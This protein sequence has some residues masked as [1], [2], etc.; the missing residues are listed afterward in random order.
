MKIFLIVHHNTAAKFFSNVFVDMG[1]YVYIPPKKILFEQVTISGNRVIEYTNIEKSNI[2]S[3]IFKFLNDVDFYDKNAVISQKI[4]RL[5]EKNFDIIISTHAVNN[6]Y[7]VNSKK[8]IYY[9]VWGASE[10]N[11]IS[12]IIKYCYNTFY[13]KI[14]KNNNSKFLICNDFLL[15]TI[16]ERKYTNKLINL[17][18]GLPKHIKKYHNSNILLTDKIRILIICSRIT[19][20]SQNHPYINKVLNYINI[21]SDFFINDDNIVISIVGKDNN[22]ILQK[23]NIFQKT[24]ELEDDL[25]EYISQSSIYINLDTNTKYIIQYSPIECAYIGI[26]TF[27]EK[28]SHI[29]KII[30]NNIS[31]N[32]FE[33]YNP[34]ILC[35][36]IKLF[37]NNTA[38][39]NEIYK[40]NNSI[41]SNKYKYD[42]LF[43]K[44]KRYFVHENNK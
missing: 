6:N 36:K 9:C 23:K 19:P 30:S 4:I 37:L 25:Y 38:E 1:Y 21:L 35:N 29:E 8:K 13:D 18:M 15:A 5:I 31:N 40:N 3:R 7:F 41:I 10:D 16:D 39:Y 17:Q 24:F 27:Y 33:F 20:Q 34:S 44:W 22:F 32:F 2:D 42:I 14:M 26:P 28:N 43:E 12:D 11:Q